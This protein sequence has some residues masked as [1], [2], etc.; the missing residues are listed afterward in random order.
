[1]Q[2]CITA[3]NNIVR[4]QILCEIQPLVI[5]PFLQANP[6]RQY[7]S[8]FTTDILCTSLLVMKPI[9]QTMEKTEAQSRGSI[10]WAVQMSGLVKNNRLL[11]KRTS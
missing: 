9:V 6:P 8:V 1:M 3:A 2:S 10:L 4:R 11:L 7:T 5:M